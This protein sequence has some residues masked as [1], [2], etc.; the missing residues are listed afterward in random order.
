M[1]YAIIFFSALQGLVYPSMNALLSRMTDASHQGALQGGMASIASDRR[2]RRPAGDDPGARLR[3]RAWRAGRRLPAR[4][5]AGP[6][7]AADRHLRRGAQVEAGMRR[8]RCQHFTAPDGVDARLARAGRG[9]GRSSCSTASS[10]TP[11]PTGSASAMPPRSP[12]RG[13]RVIMPDLRGHGTSARPHEAVGL[14]A[15]HARRRRPGA[16]RPSRPRGLRSRRLFAGR[17]D[18]G[19][20][21]R[22]R[23]RAAAADRRRHGARRG[24]STP[25]RAP[26][27]SR[28]S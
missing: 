19:P 20:D 1:V 7:C 9:A 28:R 11:T 4:R 2:D 15:R 22:A 5:R 18:G 13:F 27:I 24:C 10:P 8:E 16:D 3:R 6:C 17:A 14:S 26:A 21:G 23:R 12:A 25:A